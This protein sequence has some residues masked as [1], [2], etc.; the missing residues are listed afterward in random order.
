MKPMGRKYYLNK[1]GSKYHI[2]VNG[3]QST[4][5]GKICLPSKSRDREIAKLEIRRGK[6]EYKQTYKFRP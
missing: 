6:Y 2:R 3:K 1:T 5:W 4:W